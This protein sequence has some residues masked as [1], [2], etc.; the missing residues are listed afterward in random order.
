MCTPLY[1]NLPGSAMWLLIAAGL[2]QFLL[3]TERILYRLL[4]LLVPLF[5]GQDDRAAVKHYADNAVLGSFGAAVTYILLTPVNFLVA[6]I[7]TLFRNVWLFLFVLF[8]SG[9]LLIVS[10]NFARAM[11]LYVSTYNS[12]VGQYLD[13]KFMF[14]EILEW[15]VRMLL[16]IY[17]SVVW[18]I[19]Q[20]ILQVFLPLL[21]NEHVFA[22]VPELL[23]NLTLSVSAFAVSLASYTSNIL[24]CASGADHNGATT[25]GFSPSNGTESIP[26]S[27]A[28]LQC[29]G[30]H[31]F[32]T[33]DLMT[34][35]SF[36]QQ[37]VTNVQ[38][39]LV[40]SCSPVAFMIEFFLYPLTDFN[41]YKAV[42]CI[43]NFVLST[44]V[45][46]PLMTIKR[47]RYAQKNNDYFFPEEVS[48]MCVPDFAPWVSTLNEGLRAGGSLV[49][50]W[51]DVGLA[52]VERVLGKNQELCSRARQPGA[53]V[54]D[55]SSFFGV[56]EGL[57]K[58]VQL[59]EAMSAVTDG[60]ST[61]Y[62][63]NTDST[64]SEMAIG[65]W[66]FR[67]EPAWGVAAVRAGG[68]EDADVQ[69]NPRT[70]LFGC[71]CVDEPVAGSQH[72]RLR[73]LCASVPYVGFHD[74]E[75]AHNASTVH[76]ITFT[77][78]HVRTLMQCSN[79]LIRVHSLRF[80]RKRFAD[81]R[82]PAPL[83]DLFDTRRMYGE[84][85]PVSHTADAA[86]YI[87]PR[88][89]DG[90]GFGACFDT[91]DTCFPFCLG[92]HLA[93]QTGANI[94][95]HNA[96]RWDEFLTFAQV[97]CVGGFADFVA[98]CDGLGVSSQQLGDGSFG[99][100]EQAVCDLQVC[101]ADASSH[102]AIELARLA[103]G[104]PL[105]GALRNRSDT[106]YGGWV[107]LDEQPF[108]VAGDVMLRIVSR[109]EGRR[110]VLTRLFDHN[111][112]QFS[113]Q[114]E[115]LGLLH[116]EGAE[117]HAD[118]ICQ[119][120]DD[121]E[122][123][124]NA[125]AAGQ[126]VLPPSYFTS[127]QLNYVPAA[128]SE[129]AVHWAVNPEN[130]VYESRIL[131]CQGI[132][133]E[134]IA[135]P[136]SYG[137][138]RIWTLHTMRA[139][140][141]DTE[142]ATAQE[143]AGVSFM[144]I[145]NW[146]DPNAPFSGDKSQCHTMFGM[147]VTDLEYID[148]Q[149]VLVTVLTTSMLNYDL[150]TH[151]GRDPALVRYTRYFLHPTRRDCVDPSDAYEKTIY[152]CYR[153]ESA[154]PFTSAFVARNNQLLG[155]FCPA[156]RRM[157]QLGSGAA[158]ILV[159][160]IYTAKML[161]DAVSVLPVA[162][163][164]TVY[165]LSRTEATFHSVL[166]GDF[167]VVDNIVDSL[168]RA[169][170]HI[171]HT[172]PRL[173]RFMQN[174]PGYAELQPRLIG[175]A[176]LLQH[177][178][179]LVRLRG[180][181]S[182]Q[183]RSVEAIPVTQSMD[184]GRLFIATASSPTGDVARSVTKV[185]STG[186]STLRLNLRLLRE[187]VFKS[188]MTS[189]KK[190]GS[191]A[192]R[193]L[194]QVGSTLGNSARMVQRTS[195]LS[196]NAG[197]LAGSSVLR[198][199]KI[200][201]F[202]GLM[203]TTLFEAQDDIRRYFL[204]VL[205]V[206]CQ[207]LGEVVGDNP[208]GRA[209]RHMCSLI[210]D[211]IEGV[212]RTLLVLA[213]D[214]PL[215]DCVCRQTREVDAE[216]IV[217]DRCLPQLYPIASRTYMINYLRQGNLGLPTCFAYMDE[218]NQRLLDAFGPVQ[219][220]MH[221]AGD[222]LANALD[223]LLFSIPGYDAGEC[224]NYDASA[225]VMAL[226]PEPVGYFMGCMHTY[227]CRTRCFDVITAFEQTLANL[228]TPPFFED[229]VEVDVESRFFSDA[230]IEAGRDRLPFPAYGMA[231]LSLA[232]CASICTDEQQDRCLLLLGIDN[233]TYVAARYYCVPRSFTRSVYD[234]NPL[235]ST[236]YHSE[237][238]ESGESKVLSMWTLTTNAFPARETLL[239]SV[240]NRTSTTT[241]LWVY[242]PTGERFVLVATGVFNPEDTVSTQA[243]LQEVVNVR[244]TPRGMSSDQIH[245]YV[246][247]TRNFMRYEDEVAILDSEEIC[248][249][250]TILSDEY[251][252]FG[253]Q[254]METTCIPALQSPATHKIVVVDAAG[255]EVWLPLDGTTDKLRLYNLNDEPPTE[256]TALNSLHTL[257][258]DPA[259][260]LVITQE[261]MA[262]PNRKYMADV[263]ETAYSESVNGIVTLNLLL[264][265]SMDETQAW[266]NNLRIELDPTAKTYTSDVRSSERVQQTVQIQA[267][268]S[269]DNC[270]ACQTREHQ[271]R[272]H[273][274][275]M[276]CYAAAECAVAR[277]VGTLVNMRKPLCNLGMLLVQR[278]M[279]TARIAL[280]AMW[281]AI[282][283][284][285]IVIVELTQA[286]RQRYELSSYQEY[287]TA[288]TCSTKDS[289]VSGAATF[290]SV[291]GAVT[292][293]VHGLTTDDLNPK[294]HIID[295]N[296]NG[297][298][299]LGL[300][301]IT[302]FL[303]SLAMATIFP[304]ILWNKIL[305]CQ[306]DSALA[307][308]TNLLGDSSGVRIEI[309]LT[310]EPLERAS[311]SA[312][313]VC[314]SEYSK[315]FLRDLSASKGKNKIASIISNLITDIG[316]FI[317][318]QFFSPYW[319]TAEA[320]LAY[321]YGVVTSLMDVVQTL[322]WDNCKL[323]V[324]AFA[325]VDKCACGDQQVMIPTTRKASSVR[326]SNAATESLW[327]TGLMLLTAADG[328]DFLI[329]NPYSLEELLQPNYEAYVACLASVDSL[330]CKEPVLPD[331]D[332][333]GVNTLQVITR[334]RTN[335]QQA[336]WD[337]ASVIYGLLELEVWRN[338]QALLTTAA[339]DSI[340][341]TD[342]IARRLLQLKV[343]MR[344]N[345]NFLDPATHECFV[346]ANNLELVSH[347]CAD[348]YY[349]QSVYG[350]AAGYFQYQKSTTGLFKERDA[351][352]VFTGIV[353]QPTGGA[354]YPFT[355]W[356]G[357]SRNKVPL[358]KLHQVEVGVIAERDALAQAELDAVVQ[359]SID[360][361]SQNPFLSEQAGELKI[362]YSA[363][364][365]DSLHQ[366]VD[367]VVLGPYAAADMQTSFRLPSGLQMPV[368][369]YHRGNV[370]SRSFPSTEE[371]GGSEV[372]RKLLGAA[373]EVVKDAYETGLVDIVEQ[374]YQRLKQK[375]RN[376]QNMYCICADN[377]RG[378]ACCREA[379]H[380]TEL[381]FDLAGE[382]DRTYDIFPKLQEVG[383]EA[384]Y[385]EDVFLADLWANEAF[386]FHVAHEFSDEEKEELA[387]MHLFNA[388]FRVGTYS[389]S[390]ALVNST[391]QTLWARCMSLLST[392]FFTLPLRADEATAKAHANTHYDPMQPPF[393]THEAY[394]HGMEHAIAA[395][396]ERAREQSPVF[397]THPHRYV[398]SESVW[399]ESDTVDTTPVRTVN[400][401]QNLHG[402]EFSINGLEAPNIRDVRY[403]AT[404]AC[405][406]ALTTDNECMVPPDLC[407][408]APDLPACATGK[409]STR[410]DLFAVLDAMETHGILCVSKPSVTWGLLNRDEHVA[411]FQGG[412][413]SA[414]AAVSLHD[415]AVFGPGGVRLGMLKDEGEDSLHEHTGKINLGQHA[416]AYPM[417]SHLYR[418]TVG[419][420]ACTNTPSA[421]PGDFAE[422]D[423]RQY[424]RDTLFPVA[425]SVFVAP[426]G[427]ECSTWVVE[428][429]LWQVLHY[430]KGEAAT[431]TLEQ[432]AREDRARGRCLVQLQQIGIC[433]LRGVFDIAPPGSDVVPAHCPFKI[434]TPHSCTD[435]F[436]V[437]QSCIV[438]CNGELYDPCLCAEETCTGHEF[439]PAT[440]CLLRFDPRAFAT[441][442]EL[443]LHSMHWP[444][445]VS[446]QETDEG[447]ALEIQV[448]LD[449]VRDRL[450]S[451]EYDVQKLHDSVAHL[452]VEHD[453]QP[454][455]TLHEACGD[456]LD[457]F[458]GSE[459]HPV[460]YH[461]TRPC[462]LN[463][464][465][466]RGFDAWMSM[467]VDPETGETDG[468]LVDPIRLRNMTLASR[469]FGAGHVLCDA[470]AYGA[471]G[472]DLNP[473]TLETKW[474]GD[475]R[476]DPTLPLDL[477]PEMLDDMLTSGAASNNGNDTPCAHHF[478]PMLVHSVGLVRD[479]LRLYGPD[480]ELQAAYDNLWPHWGDA[481]DPPCEYGL[482][483]GAPV[484]EGC[485]H[486]PLFMCKEDSD[487]TTTTGEDLVCLQGEQDGI[488]A[489]RNSCFRHAHCASADQL[490][491]GEGECVAARIF[492]EHSGQQPEDIAVQLL[493]LASNTACNDT[494]RGTSAHHLLPTFAQ[495]HGLCSARNWFT[496]RQELANAERDEYT[497]TYVRQLGDFPL[498][499]P[500]E[501]GEPQSIFERQVLHVQPHPCDR[502]FLQ[503]DVQL[504]SPGPVQAFA[505]MQEA[506]RPSDSA[507]EHVLGIRT[508]TEGSEGTRLHRCHLP[509]E[510]F[511]QT[512]GF[513]HPYA[514]VAGDTLAT[515]R[516]NLA[517][518]TRFRVCQQFRFLVDGIPVQTRRVAVARWDATMGTVKIA[519]SEFRDFSAADAD[520]CWGMGYRVSDTTDD[521]N[522]CVVDRFTA[523][524]LYVLANR[525]GEP[526][527]ASDAFLEL[528]STRRQARYDQIRQHCP[529]AFAHPINSN[530]L[531]EFQLF[532]D[533]LAR[534][535]THYF[536]NDR[537][538]IALDLNMLLLAFFGITQT[539]INRGFDSLDG[540]LAHSTCA[541]FLSRE[542]LQVQAGLRTLDI[543]RQDNLAPEQNPGS[544]LYLFHE[545]APLSLSPKWFWQCVVLARSNEEGAPAGWFERATDPL[546]TAIADTLAC[547]LF[548]VQPTAEPVT[549]KRLLQISNV[550]ELSETEQAN[551]LDNKQQ[552]VHALVDAV[553]AAVAAGLD[554]LGLTQS[555]QM[556]CMQAKRADGTVL[557]E[558]FKENSCYE[559]L[560]QETCWHKTCAE[561]CDNIGF[562]ENY[563][564]Y[565]EA[566]EAV[567]QTRSWTNARTQNYADLESAGLI[568]I[569]IDMTE[570][571]SATSRFIPFIR[572]Q[573]LAAA[574][575]QS[576]PAANASYGRFKNDFVPATYATRIDSTTCAYRLLHPEFEALDG[577]GPFQE[578]PYQNIKFLRYLTF[579]K[580]RFE[581]LRYVENNIHDH[582][583]SVDTWGDTL[584]VSSDPQLFNSKAGIATGAEQTARLSRAFAYSK[585]M[586][587]K[588]YPCGDLDNFRLEL[589]T[590]D[591]PSQLRACA[592]ELKRPIA[593][594]VPQ[595]TILQVRPGAEPLLA[596]FFLA[597]TPAPNA[598]SF[599]D[600]MLDENWKLHTSMDRAVCFQKEDGSVTPLNPLWAGDYDTTSCP[601]GACGCDT[602]IEP[603]EGR[604]VD[605]RCGGD[606]NS[607]F[608]AFHR[609]M[610]DKMPQE[611]LA[612]GLEQTPVVLRR[613]SLLASYTPLCDLVN[614]MDA[615]AVGCEIR[616]SFGA[617]SG[618]TG[619][620]ASSLYTKGPRPTPMSGGLFSASNSIFRS[621]S[622]TP[623]TLPVLRLLASDIGGSALHF[624]LEQD[625][626]LGQTLQLACAMLKSSP[627]SK[628]TAGERLW[629]ANVEESWLWQHNRLYNTW[630]TPPPGLA[631]WTCPLQ[632]LSAYSGTARQH[633]F[634]AQVPNRER[635]RVRFAHV[636]GTSHFAHPTVQSV[637]TL[638]HLRPARYKA[639]HLMCAE[640]RADCTGGLSDVIEKLKT[641]AWTIV[642]VTAGDDTCTQILDW[643][644]QTFR[645]RDQTVAEERPAEPCFALDRLPRFA[646]RA[647][648][649]PPRSPMPQHSPA[650]LPGG[651]CHMG[652][653]RRLEKSSPHSHHLQ[654][655]QDEPQLQA[656]RCLS[657]IKNSTTN[658]FSRTREY[659]FEADP[660]VAQPTHRR[661]ADLPR[662]R[663]SM[664]DAVHARVLDPMLTE[665]TLADAP[666]QLS[667]GQ[668]VRVSTERLLAAYL[669][670]KLCPNATDAVCADLRNLFE[671]TAWQRGEFLPRIL[672]TDRYSE[673]F[674]AFD[675][676]RLPVQSNTSHL[677]EIGDAMLWARPWVFCDQSNQSVGC[678][679]SIPRETWLNPQLRVTQ[680]AT[681]IVENQAQT[682]LVSFCHL[683]AQTAKLC[684]QIV[685]WNTRIG[686]ALCTAAGL[687]STDAFFYNPAA[688]SIDNQDFVSVSVQDF[689]VTL[690][691]GAECNSLTT[692]LAAA[693]I[694][695]NRQASGRCSSTYLEILRK[696]IEIARGVL[697]I[698]FKAMYYALM[699][700]AQLVQIFI[701]AVSD[702]AEVRSSL[703]GEAVTRLLRYIKLFLQTVV[704][705][706]KFIINAFWKLLT[707][708]DGNFGKT[709]TDI[710][711]FMCNVVKW[712]Q[713]AICWLLEL[714]SDFWK[715]TVHALKDANEFS[716][717]VLGAS[718]PLGRLLDPILK[719]MIAYIEK[720]KLPVYNM[721]HRSVCKPLNC[722][723][724][725]PENVG[726]SDGTLPVATRCWTTHSAVF[727]DRGGLGCTAADT[728]RASQIDSSLMVC[729]QCPASTT[730]TIATFQC[731]PLL[732]MCS[733]GVP[734][735]T[736]TFCSSNLECTDPLATCAYINS[737]LE[738]ST[739][740]VDCAAC[741]TARVCFLAPGA[742][743]GVCACPLFKTP[744]SSCTKQAEIVLPEPD[745]FCLLAPD[746]R[747]TTSAQYTAAWS[748][749]LTA[750][751]RSLDPTAVYCA[752]ILDAAGSNTLYAVGTR[753]SEVLP[754]LSRRRLL[755]FREIVDASQEALERMLQ[756]HNEYASQLI[757][758]FDYEYANL[759]T[760][761]A[762]LGWV[763]QWPPDPALA[764]AAAETCGPFW[765]FAQIFAQAAGNASLPLTPAGR[766]M[767]GEPGTSLSAA[768]PRVPR[769]ANST[770][771]GEK[772]VRAGDAVVGTWV[773]FVRR[774]LDAVGFSR[775]NVF[776][777]LKAFFNEILNSVKCD[778][779][780][781]QTCK[782]WKVLLFHSVI[783]NAVFFSIW[784]F[785]ANSA[786]LSFFASMSVMLFVPSVLYLSYGYSPACIPMIPTC[787]FEDAIRSLRL[788]F[789]RFMRVPHAFVR[790]ATFKGEACLV[791][792]ETCYAAAEAG[793]TPIY[794]EDNNLNIRKPTLDP[795][796]CAALFTEQAAAT[797]I[798]ECQ[799]SPLEFT[800]WRAVFAWFVAE[801]GQGAV[802]W[803]ID[804]QTHIPFL[805][806]HDMEAQL[807][808]KNGI[809]RLNDESLVTAHRVCA[810]V[811]SYL[812][813]PYLL[814][815]FLLATAVVATLIVVLIPA[816]I[817]L[818]GTIAQ[819]YAAIF[820]QRDPV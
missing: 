355:L 424:L 96:K 386:T 38:G 14:L 634:A 464:S 726:S 655:C 460:G 382:L 580:G 183:L 818:F 101:S 621:R 545:F 176:K 535:P 154:G 125:V 537:A 103:E 266:I 660:P 297:R 12:G 400:F 820:V 336:R 747:F 303:S 119:T 768:W 777:L 608:P 716:F 790:D 199:A 3:I 7:S 610:Q 590:N 349:R 300:A 429:A 451:L 534:L 572:L 722:N 615:F 426:A 489:R 175:T 110:L 224:R 322:D 53:V 423:L 75:T 138:P 709:L 160:N 49:D 370:G 600:Y 431:D 763:A 807:L 272:Y 756:V 527:V 240:L 748:T 664:C 278:Q 667:V 313:G 592:R 796:A 649:V 612:L 785:V 221:R 531:V 784:F 182:G 687:C 809:W 710:V 803:A 491:S 369:Q 153:Q 139:A 523:P 438:M 326:T 255:R 781:V 480:R 675:E 463:E 247:G 381:R 227:D 136:S 166:Y 445:Q 187:F 286:R 346:R 385:R 280:G 738:V 149:N 581:L 289:I 403:P 331:L 6:V 191:T 287:F 488:C 13:L 762:A 441:H 104:A 430:T 239:V 319:H 130:I 564:L 758:A 672:K 220:R 245:I 558:P 328:K 638:A 543:Y 157:P 189:A 657:T 267:E 662:R 637:S 357:S 717:K 151:T 264:V 774:A 770:W 793:F 257:S 361:F 629:L 111:A 340:A 202:A 452:V 626:T 373:F 194:K 671:S 285:T 162:S 658:A 648:Y 281:T 359:E 696:I 414:E 384:L 596:G 116:G 244:V 677:A 371:T 805:D 518:C 294:S 725:Y 512:T 752:L 320:V 46:L 316:F 17:N 791:R 291:I 695:S 143:P 455:G 78:D 192:Q 200:A 556:H 185:A 569:D 226:M 141:F 588:T 312:V 114:H 106:G 813:V 177:S 243:K 532:E 251:A 631:P 630:P 159:A 20:F 169:A 216:S 393:A 788:V 789:P 377:S 473:Y 343:Y 145:P 644:E 422:S 206:Q 70:G 701:A 769:Q 348:T 350:S 704:E 415:V 368:A 274:V 335:Y 5:Y 713:E 641:R 79:T 164:D 196:G 503:A 573:G 676:E 804:V 397:W 509:E 576:D 137:V 814:L 515:T 539:D 526:N 27:N 647:K 551:V 68:T 338:P 524:L 486:P 77:D 479:W 172:L 624:A 11:L 156:M 44:V 555:P 292:T 706:W 142:A 396:L 449:I 737:D 529:K 332:A 690:D 603:G 678:K 703:L 416:S 91:L 180:A 598:P 446:E 776:D 548:D 372:R 665:H 427:A 155:T 152:S 493:S 352:E 800:S 718:V 52:M 645:L 333:Q 56:W 174:V 490:C 640:T 742:T 406:C 771:T 219:Q 669:R 728:C 502:D 62:Y 126:L 459:Q 570:E 620:P 654:M 135:L 751:C 9:V 405:A 67:V 419:Q 290:T 225:Y 591:I 24:F 435:L 794:V 339:F 519:P 605:T 594:R 232:A 530:S 609:L 198:T 720:I 282:A 586:R 170:M 541:R 249:F 520:T 57:L 668:P 511:R 120:L 437:T 261:D 408:A 456:M 613:G 25:Y 238:G 122:C 318:N 128:A 476:T 448:L 253:F 260:A 458:D 2:L 447:T 302:N 351:C 418:H 118:T 391:E 767:K 82:T 254:V 733:C 723:L 147:R 55:S 89:S 61:L 565:S 688:Y 179:D 575:V 158:E 387:Q 102:T 402:Q 589:E 761:S 425:H 585:H 213:I 293:S 195:K 310:K 666:A 765:N 80:S 203:S 347:E 802:D 607:S 88:C 306:A 689:Y 242:T 740:F 652:P 619:Q 715:A 462:A 231:E 811:H 494:M 133:V 76:E 566:L 691:T 178:D 204:D 471:L 201:T 808:L 679:G 772:S 495:D 132:L 453:S 604:I 113:L 578:P 63:T 146:F 43:F 505:G 778:F 734:Q 697:D 674:V 753:T 484:Q 315:E 288:L 65:N 112:G 197:I 188:L 161:L 365:G 708:L 469:F 719:P 392:P 602:Y 217:L 98:D 783:V 635:N 362:E 443:L 682:P 364:E 686:K 87:Q 712:V 41:L 327:C 421:L 26:F 256:F 298:L 229:E 394:L 799:D 404:L 757:T 95:A 71:Q 639:D 546:M 815:T 450:A 444:E 584:H 670:R 627:E 324:T 173:G 810:F 643:P 407:T 741:S 409:Y 436:Y 465:V 295:A 309:S 367:C 100:R 663:C 514:P 507:I 439:V 305:Q 786:Q 398:P 582:F 485:A 553:Q 801:L 208:F 337:P 186:S 276:K 750:P 432:Q 54:A 85:P 330:D 782:N 735:I 307:T 597:F 482:P 707:E 262:V 557:T 317:T 66:P 123:Y 258:V 389:A 540:Y 744:Q 277:C 538:Q 37:A 22:S 478:S 567:F 611:C 233:S 69:A 1:S 554:N 522:L 171:A 250:Y 42:H 483:A 754:G 399:C 736:Q 739:G 461:P 279:D 395:I 563:N 168:A 8:L 595:D 344:R 636:T 45:T 571:V 693:Q 107:R 93:G 10:E 284:S 223:Y 47:C 694:E 780:A 729:A 218:A 410:E 517:P 379:Q 97:E 86:V 209:T 35:G 127:Q 632:W 724:E 560:G 215:M 732:K 528:G 775:D 806:H 587:E 816:L 235:F 363:W 547:P 497:S 755:G 656:L 819:L 314:L 401:R 21:G 360:F 265:G 702:I 299:V 228:D 163:I 296:T 550:F 606:C 64:F 308:F 760:S 625:A 521:I 711:Q 259:I 144:T 59:T 342:A 94:T 15:F 764:A 19:Q 467:P 33:F 599:L 150:I 496:F 714:L 378:L 31:A 730:T 73:V 263:S 651:A 525:V 129:W 468:Y 212:L 699:A 356:S 681:A 561:R 34:P 487:C 593:W 83:N 167:L 230:D 583:T 72:T 727:G 812:L 375:F 60:E 623:A 773:W 28:D 234:A 275:Q 4:F 121:N 148:E 383:M 508:W 412:E 442:P 99:V 341:A 417:H 542:L 58:Y 134:D 721:I 457:Y 787:F 549:V 562:D 684:E 797:C 475:R 749:T 36:M 92:L 601:E 568:S 140:A 659:V 544:S 795:Q 237:W 40:L 559:Y 210:P 354:L 746:S 411:W 513:L 698:L 552:P 380:E 700:V 246:T 614:D 184:R 358:S 115:Q 90:A 105:T 506:P 18:L 743:A 650:M 574:N 311:A 366:M 270:A 268:C 39:V 633:D 617:F 454:E 579:D 74:N 32:Y 248:L 241:T 190:V 500:E 321:L 817:P 434:N 374:T 207:G 325:R 472:H 376:L 165:D 329:W 205:R 779:E 283:Q 51:L 642:D 193:A 388:E 323:P 618:W 236:S 536:A 345:T 440:A 109:P 792:L 673:L 390:E 504:C 481:F 23:Q 680:C 474:N 16:P 705:Y 420:P 214:Y 353:Q 30:N 616:D 81:S 628:C 577:N 466:L 501:E 304:L 685:K 492:I 271:L 181:F 273:D 477:A 413:P 124:N 516:S 433:N 499:R 683:N 745:A 428:Y 252:D 301:A 108:V 48:I 131:R 269:L 510:K 211:G 334:C 661:A 84:L 653:L 759:Y 798:R 766:E 622:F 646:I 470:S 533:L 498:Q 29:V 50:N 222:A 731:D 692:H 117:V